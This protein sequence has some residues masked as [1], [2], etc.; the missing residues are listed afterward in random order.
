MKSKILLLLLLLFLSATKLFAFI[1]LFNNLPDQMRPSPVIGI[2]GTDFTLNNEPFNFTGISFFNALYNP[3]F[4]SN[5]Q[6]QLLWLKK[7]KDYG[8]TVVRIW[9][10]WNNDLEFID[11]CD[12]CT[13]YNHNGSLNPIYLDRLK[14]L[15][16]ASASLNMVIEYVLFSSESKNKKLSD[17]AAN[18]AVFNITKELKSYRNTV[19]QIWN[20]YDYRV[21]DYYYIIKQ[22]DPERLVTNSPGGGGTLGDDDH[23]E[24][25]DFLTPHTSRHNK[26]WEIAGNEISDLIKKFNKPVVDDEPARSGTAETEWLGG[27][28]ERTTPFDHILQIYNVWRSGGYYTYH[29][30]MFQTGYGTAPIPCHGIPDPEFNSYHRTVFEFIREKSRFDK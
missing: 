14:E 5:T 17:D 23:N 24:L 30:D 7:M 18:R 21:K 13:L 22:N 6:T 4:N 10:E 3:T 1:F 11:T 29:H 28:K 9:G 16:K 19:F 2:Q 15:L 25:L 26:F 12:A 27:P 8:I 20:E